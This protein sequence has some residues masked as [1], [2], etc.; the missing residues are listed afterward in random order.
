MVITSYHMKYLIKKFLLLFYTVNHERYYTDIDCRVKKISSKHVEEFLFHSHY[1]RMHSTMNMNSEELWCFGDSLLNSISAG[2]RSENL[3]FYLD[4]CI[5]N[6]CSINKVALSSKKLPETKLAEYMCHQRVM[7]IVFTGLNSSTKLLFARIKDSWNQFKSLQPSCSQQKFSQKNV[8]LMRFMMT[9]QTPQRFAIFLSS[10]NF[11]YG[12]LE[13]NE[14]CIAKL[15]TL[16]LNKHFMP[17]FICLGKRE[18]IEVS[19][20]NLFILRCTLF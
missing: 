9:N 10:R 15:H 11:A 18:S 2:H 8:K 5:K 4:C 6:I 17:M 19:I 16:R 3:I 7:H 14:M 13:E 12:K 1:S 20:S